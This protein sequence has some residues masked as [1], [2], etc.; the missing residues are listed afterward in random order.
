MKSHHNNS[1][2]TAHYTYTNSSIFS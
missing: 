1:K 2:F